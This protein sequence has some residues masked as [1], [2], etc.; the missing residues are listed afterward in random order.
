[1]ALK[2]TWTMLLALALCLALAC[3]AAAGDALKIGVM[4]PMSG[5]LAYTGQQCLR[6][7][8]I[9]RDMINEAGGVKGKKIQFLVGDSVSPKDAMAEAERLITIEKVPVISGG[10]SSS[11]AFAASD[12]CERHKT[13]FWIT[14]GVGDPITSR[15]YKYIF[16]LNT[17][18]SQ[19]GSTTADFLAKMA[20]P[21]LGIKPADFKL[22]LIHEDSLFGTIIGDSC[23]ARA[24]ELGLKVVERITY[25][26]K[27]VDLSSEIAKLKAAG[28]DGIVSIHYVNDGN[29]FYG[30][31]KQMRL[32]A[33]VLV[34]S[35]FFGLNQFQK[36]FGSLVD[37]VC[38]VDPPT[39]VEASKISKPAAEVL[40]EFRKRFQAKYK[41]EP[42]DPGFT[43][44]GGTYVLLK[45]V[46]P[47]A[48]AFDAKSI[49]EAALSLD[50][51]K[52]ETPYV[53]GVKF[54][55]PPAKTAGAN[56]NAFPVIMQWQKQQLL[57]VYPENLASAP[58]E[59]PM[60]TWKQRKK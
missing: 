11:N 28:A 15:G 35:V 21:K 51:P 34:G 10:Y 30:Q 4:Y 23:V 60:P 5:P 31:A 32:N 7:A 12:V 13:V 38:V 1:M 20:A 37:Y 53:F 19:W 2:K 59:L 18:A 36:K 9:A 52:L 47:K 54:E 16:Q 46:L 41:E 40:T 6:G 33:K 56:L 27:T 43:A 58:V 57:V 26:H 55:Q 50:L 42:G 25:S 3:P 49:Q 39:R 14:T 17:R 24:K 44:F 45:N 29:L 8:E 48:K 22:A